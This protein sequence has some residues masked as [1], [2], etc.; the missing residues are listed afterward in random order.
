[1]YVHGTHLKEYVHNHGV[2]QPAA[3]LTRSAIAADERRR[4]DR[5]GPDELRAVVEGLRDGGVLDGPQAH[6]LVE[7]L[8]LDDRARF[9]DPFCSPIPSP[10]R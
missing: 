5:L 4:S 6:S 7:K 10:G 1:M 8:V 9:G 2:D 3:E